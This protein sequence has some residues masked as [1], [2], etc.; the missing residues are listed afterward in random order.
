MAVNEVLVTLLEV[1]SCL[2]VNNII[3]GDKVKQKLRFL[4]CFKGT[5]IKKNYII[6][7]LLV[8]V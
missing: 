4:L 3:E 8:S 2:R 1:R 5:S 7:K 6:K